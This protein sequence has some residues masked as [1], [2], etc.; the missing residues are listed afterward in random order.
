[1]TKAAIRNVK[2]HLDLKKSQCKLAGCP[3]VH[4]VNSTSAILGL[5]THLVIIVCICVLKAVVSILCLSRSSFISIDMAN[6]DCPTRSGASSGA[7]YTI[8]HRCIVCTGRIPERDLHLI[9]GPIRNKH[10][11]IACMPECFDNFEEI[12]EKLNQRDHRAYWKAI[13]EQDRKFM[14]M[15]SKLRPK[16]HRLSKSR[17]FKNR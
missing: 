16:L 10:L 8:L 1:M 15:K 12:N 9:H 2:T 7:Y 4:P 5:H 3:F 13:R 14:N 6:L 11:H 17:C